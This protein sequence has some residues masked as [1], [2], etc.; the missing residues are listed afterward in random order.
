MKATNWVKPKSRTT[1]EKSADNYE[2]TFAML[3]VKSKSMKNQF[4][5]LG[6]AIVEDD[7]DTVNAVI[8]YFNESSNS[9]LTGEQIDGLKFLAE[10]A[11]RG[12]EAMAH[13]QL[14]ESYF[15]KHDFS[16]IKKIPANIFNW[17]DSQGVDR[18]QNSEYKKPNHDPKDRGYY[19]GLV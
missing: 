19:G 14:Y 7:H 18:N 5:K 1:D 15:P 16:H 4:R 13:R 10:T 12:P 6:A 3:G 11:E 17:K 2:K 9:K 8:N